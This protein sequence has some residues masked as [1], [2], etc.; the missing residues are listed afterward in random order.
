MKDFEEFLRQCDIPP[1]LPWQRKMIESFFDPANKDK[2][3][4]W[5]TT[6]R[7][8]GWMWVEKPPEP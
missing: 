1:L 6:R 8:G 5:V 2:H 4:R 7:G 3:L